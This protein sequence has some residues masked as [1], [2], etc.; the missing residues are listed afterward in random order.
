[1]KK[2]IYNNDDQKLPLA[3]GTERGSGI[4]FAAGP[5]IKKQGQIFN[6]C[7]YDIAPIILNIF[8]VPVP[9]DID[10]KIPVNLFNSNKF[11]STNSLDQEYLKSRKQSNSK[12][13]QE[14]V[15]ARL[16]DLGYF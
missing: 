2:I 5:D 11:Q 4:F 6:L 16:K 14:K 1:M 3:L 7:L 13:Q 10:G 9:N 8:N 15:I 12:K